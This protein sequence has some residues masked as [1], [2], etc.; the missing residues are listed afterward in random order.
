MKLYFIF[1]L[2]SFVLS[3]FVTQANENAR[4]IMKRSIELEDGNNRTSDM[5]MTL[6]DKHNEK[7]TRKLKGYSKDKGVDNLSLMVF[8]APNDV[9]GTGFLTIDYKDEAKDDDQWLYLPALR[10]VKRVAGSDKKGSFMGS[11]FTYGDMTKRSLSLYNYKILKEKVIAG[12]KSWIIEVKPV[13]QDV[14]NK[15]GY[16][17]SIVFVRQDNYFIIRAIHW[18]EKGNK[19]KYLQVK[20][21]DL[22]D[23]VWVAKESTMMTKIGKKIIHK[24]MLSYENIKFNQSLDES[25]FSVRQL[26]KIF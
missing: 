23:N 8:T 25:L 17:K 9:K 2:C 18:L 5:T 14:V 26:E 1:I 11:D 6:V 4:Q 15:Y 22:I 20:K 10:K 12:I 24:T 21:L 16:T 13:N 7:R 19:V 3:P